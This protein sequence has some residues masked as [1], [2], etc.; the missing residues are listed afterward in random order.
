MIANGPVTY[1]AHLE[2]G[3]GKKP[4]GDGLV[5]VQA[6]LI[7]HSEYAVGGLGAAEQAGAVGVFQAGDYR[8][9][10]RDEIVRPQL[11]DTDCPDVIALI[12]ERGIVHLQVIDRKSTRLNSSH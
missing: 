4:C 7:A 1:A 8:R 2:I 3:V 11:A 9:G 12:V 6:D 10:S 5:E